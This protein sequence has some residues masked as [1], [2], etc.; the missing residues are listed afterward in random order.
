MARGA[1]GVLVGTCESAL[2]MQQTEL[3]ASAGAFSAGSSVFGA[4][5]KGTT[6]SMLF[7]NAARTISTSSLMP[8]DR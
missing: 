4:W 7:N 5:A 6:S 3:A 1:R 8:S 2:A